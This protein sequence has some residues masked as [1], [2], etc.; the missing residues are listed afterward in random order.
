MKN[1]KTLIVFITFGLL[2]SSCAVLNKYEEQKTN[3]DLT[4][5]EEKGIFVTT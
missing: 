1:L 4:T 3:I 2:I 5:F